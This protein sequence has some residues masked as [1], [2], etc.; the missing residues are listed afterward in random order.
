MNVP[1]HA[2]GGNWKDNTGESILTFYTLEIRSLLSTP[3]C[4]LHAIGPWNS[5]SFLLPLLPITP[6]EC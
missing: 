2:C 4:A 5:G 1:G 3:R 6:P